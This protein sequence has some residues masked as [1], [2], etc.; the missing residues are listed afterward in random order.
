MFLLNGLPKSSWSEQN[1]T[2]RSAQR[3]SCSSQRVEMMCSA[4]QTHFFMC[5]QVSST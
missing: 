3:M 1:G 2:D 4:S 5:L